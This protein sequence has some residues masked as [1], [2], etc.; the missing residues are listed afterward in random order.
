VTTLSIELSP[1]QELVV[2]MDKGIFE[3]LR[4]AQQGK[5]ADAIVAAVAVRED[6]ARGH[7][8]L[9]LACAAAIGVCLAFVLIRHWRLRRAS[10]ARLA[11]AKRQAAE[12]AASVPKLVGTIAELKQKIADLEQKEFDP[13]ARGT[14]DGAGG[15]R[16]RRLRAMIIRELHP[17]HAAGGAIDRAQRSELFKVIWPKMEEIDRA[18]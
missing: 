12:V 14:E 6:T 15:Q 16:Y 9:A 4:P 7:L 10:N 11:L 2:Q 1:G 13:R 8:D 3:S 17:D 5:V 18:A